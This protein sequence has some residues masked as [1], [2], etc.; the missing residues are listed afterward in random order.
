MQNAVYGCAMIYVVLY[1]KVQRSASE[2]ALNL[3]STKIINSIPA[4]LAENWYH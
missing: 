1:N 3:L 4:L 2:A